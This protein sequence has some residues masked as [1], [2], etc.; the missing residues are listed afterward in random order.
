MRMRVMS[1]GD[2]ILSN[3]AGVEVTFIP[4]SVDDIDPDAQLD[5][6]LPCLSSFSVTD[7]ITSVNSYS[8]GEPSE[9]KQ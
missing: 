3:H 2:V 4:E 7:K 1:N 8:F 9:G 6:E 5:V